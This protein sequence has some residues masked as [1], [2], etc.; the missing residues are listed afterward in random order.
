MSQAPFVRKLDKIAYVAGT[1]MIIGY[2]SLMGRYPH[3]HIYTFSAIL[4]PMLV[5]PR[6]V[7][8]YLNG[9]HFFLID[10]C[11]FVNSCLIYFLLWGYSSQATFVCC[12]VYSNGPV[13]A[14]II[15][16]RNSLVYHK[17]DYLTSL[18][19]HAIPMTIM[20]HIRWYTIPE[21][22]H[23][24]KEQQR[25]PIDLPN[26]QTTG[27]FL[28]CFI[29]TPMMYYMTYLIGYGLINFVI[30]EKSIREKNYW[31][32]FTY[33]NT[34]WNKKMLTMFGDGLAPIF[35]MMAHAGFVLCGILIATA[36]FYFYHFNMTINIA[37]LLI[38]FYNGANFY[39]ESFSRKYEKDL[40]KLQRQQDQLKSPGKAQEGEAETIAEAEKLEKE[41]AK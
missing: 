17:I 27:E 33:M 30:C 40:E 11:Y 41:Q 8:Y 2:S 21:Q 9:W 16:F 18:A 20:T 7:Q 3:D 4:L 39:M 35:F 19:I 24:P 34:G 6:V 13:A 32:T 10:F 1:T 22:A 29:Y 14:G 36:S 37:Y 25:F 5:L 31:T 15:A 38:S 26:P 28:S 12:F 23:L